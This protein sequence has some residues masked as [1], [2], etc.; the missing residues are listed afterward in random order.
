MK[1]VAIAGGSGVVGARVVQHLLASEDVG[2]VVAVGR[3]ELS[4]KHAKLD[5]KVVD[6]QYASAM[7]EQLPGDVAAAFC[8]LGTTMKKAGSKEAFVEVDK[9]AVLAFAGAVLSKGAQRFLV[10]SSLGADAQSR[11]F[12]LRTKGET[13]QALAELGFAQLTVLRPSFIDDQG[14]RT[15]Q[16]PGERLGLSVARAVFSLVGKTRR[17]APISADAIAKAMVRLAF[18]DTTERVR[19]VESDRLHVLGA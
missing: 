10:V 11:S 4:V 19:T 13:E 7:A 15:D 14:A 3:R 18:D 9:H 1:T 16:R 2:R 5:S 12:Y 17:H 8:C 6:L